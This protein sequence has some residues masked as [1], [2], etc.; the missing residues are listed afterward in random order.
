MNCRDGCIHSV[1]EGGD[2]SS[3]ILSG[4]VCDNPILTQLEYETV[5]ESMDDMNFKCPYFDPGVPSL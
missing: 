1:Y 2:F 4:Y 5:T 3:G